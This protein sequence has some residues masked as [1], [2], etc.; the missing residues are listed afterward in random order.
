[1]NILFLS[2]STGGGHMNA[3]KAVKETIA[4]KYPNA[5]CLI[6]DTLRY[7]SPLLNKLIVGSYLSMV[8][9]APDFY[10]GLY[11]LSEYNKGISSLTSTSSKLIARYLTDLI[12]DFCPSIIVC[13]HTFP[14]QMVSFLKEKNVISVPIVAVVTDY[15]NHPFWNLHNIDALVVPGNHVKRDMIKTGIP[16]GIIYPFGIPLSEDFIYKN[17]KAEMR[18]TLQ[19]DDKL[20]ALIMGGSLGIRSVYNSFK[21][22]M[23]SKKDI[24]ILIVTGEN[25]KLRK[26]I[27]QELLNYPLNQQDMVRILG[28]TNNVSN[29]MDAADFIITKAG[30]MTISEAL[31]KEL[32]IFLI[33]P[34]SGQEERNTSF[35]VNSGAAVT[36]SS[37]EDI[38]NILD[39][40][41]Y[42]PE[43]L[44]RI[45]QKGKLLARP[46]ASYDTVKLFEGLLRS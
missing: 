2:V 4:S 45:K 36:I 37:K 26:K 38:D 39:N 12:K 7:I 1:M 15:V 20:T 21:L 11:K 33:S 23:N 46:N 16:K 14:L 41:I 5:K 3:A 44:E 24:Q 29:L 8:R 28:Y 32:P 17:D 27:Q 19:L 6:V 34:M 9:N 13:T 40:T 43:Q 31:A 35:L 42:N 30:G 25:N 22:L 18:R 10:G